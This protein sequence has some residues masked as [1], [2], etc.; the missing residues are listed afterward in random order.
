M[1]SFQLAC[2]GSQTS[3]PMPSDQERA[4]LSFSAMAPGPTSSFTRQRSAAAVMGCD[5]SGAFSS[6]PFLTSRTAM[7]DVAAAGRK[8]VLMPSSQ[9]SGSANAGVRWQQAAISSAAEML[10]PRVID[11]VSLP[12]LIFLLRVRFLKSGF[13]H[14]QRPRFTALRRQP[15]RGVGGAEPVIVA[16]LHD[17][18]EKPLVEGVG[19]DLEEFTLAFAVVQNLVV[20]QRSHGRGVEAVF[21]FDVVVVIVGNLQEVRAAR[22]HVGDRSKDIVAGERDVLHAGAEEFV[23]EAGRQRPRR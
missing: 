8:A 3:M 10:A 19:I 23:D 14:G 7:A 15:D 17:L 4:V 9:E 12:F 11:I 2:V 20:A 22:A 6:S 21:G 18:E 13:G 16:A 1:R 5:A